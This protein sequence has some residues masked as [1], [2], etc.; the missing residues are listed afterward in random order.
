MGFRINANRVRV[1]HGKCSLQNQ[2]LSILA[3]NGHIAGFCRDIQPMESRVEREYVR[4]FSYWVPGQYLH[5]GE[6]AHCKLVFILSRY[7][8][9][10]TPHFNTTPLPPPSSI[11]S[12]APS[13]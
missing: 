1:R 3:K 2:G 5:V 13:N 12:I 9:Q 11:P 6:I 7:N 4:V 10:S 8:D